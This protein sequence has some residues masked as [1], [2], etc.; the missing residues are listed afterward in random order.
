MSESA[1][2]T[3]GLREQRMR[4]TR[5]ELCHRARQLT[6]ERGLAGFTI[7]ELCTDVGVSRRTF[8]NYFEGKEA[9]V[10]GHDADGLDEEALAAFVRGDDEAPTLL[11]ALAELAIT[12]VSAWEEGHEAI[13]PHALVER[14]P[15]LL[16]HLIGAGRQLEARLVAAIE[17]REGLRAG[18]PRARTAAVVIGA[19]V[20]SAGHRF[21]DDPESRREDFAALLRESV[22]ATRAACAPASAPA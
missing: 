14:E 19:L 22:T 21:F 20:G 6:V 13:D 1:K 7:D 2:S 11:D 12:T 5:R 17:E 15:R 10:V 9:A 18:D 3:P 8:F 16:P 4:R